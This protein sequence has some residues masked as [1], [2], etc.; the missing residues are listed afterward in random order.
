MANP[1]IGLYDGGVVSMFPRQ[2][3]NTAVSASL[4]S[5]SNYA[6]HVENLLPNGLKA[7]SGAKRYGIG[8]KGDAIGGTTIL[9]ILEYRTGAGAIE[10]LSYCNDGTIRRLNEGTGAWTTLK[11]GLGANGNP[12]SVAFN[13]KLIVVDG[14]NTPMAYNGSTV[15]LLGEYVTDYDSGSSTGFATAASQT[16]TD[17]ITVTVLAGRND[18]V[19]GRNIRVTFATE[20]AVTAT[21]ANVSGTS[22]KTIDVSGTPFPNPTQ[23]ITK[24]EYFDNPPAFSDIYAEHQRLWALSAGESKANTYRPQ[25]NAMRVYYADATNNE[26]SWFN[27]TT[28]EVGYVNLL[29]RSR[30]FDELVRISSI[31]GAMVFFARTNTFI[32]AGDD[33][34]TLGEFAWQKTIPVGCVNGNLVQ[35]YPAD[36]LFFTRYGARSLRTVLQTEGLEVVPDLGSAVDP[37]VTSFVDN[38]MTSDALYRSARSF[39]YERDGFYGFRFGAEYILVYALSEESK[40]W[41]YFSGLFK[42]ATA[43]L[44]TTDGRLLLA[45]GGQLCAYA[46]GT[47]TAVGTT[48]SD[49]GATILAK[50]WTPWLRLKNGRWSNIGYEIQMEQVTDTVIDIYRSRDDRDDSIVL[51]ADDVPL[52]ENSAYWDEAYWDESYW[53]SANRRINVRDK[54]LA[55]SFALMIVNESTVGPLSFLGIKPIGR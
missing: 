50:W 17:T 6:R 26:N 54:F 46:N 45:D 53:D 28:H 42:D 10:L 22:V 12:R 52:T 14:I 43:Y 5:S 24:V 44:G 38:M 8:E 19:V 32:Y 48:Y 41:V 40:G 36:V 27:Q 33:P 23:T 51:T 3:M 37:T 34:T 30:R 39:F 1:R 2:L 9:D 15:E 13:E 29:N 7:G 21:I 4:L 20:G 35:K 16:D 18:Y 47:D 49:N 31:D 11:S 55:D 25:A